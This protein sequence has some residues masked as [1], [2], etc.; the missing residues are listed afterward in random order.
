MPHLGIDYSAPIGTPVSSV[1]SGRVVFA[2]WQRGFGNYAEVK[3]NSK[4]LS[5]Y[6][7]LSRFAKGIKTGAYVKQG[8]IIGYVG[9]TG[10]TTG[11]HLDFRIKDRGQCVNFLKLR[12][13]VASGGL[14]SKK[15][16]A[17]FQKATR[18][19]VQELNQ[20]IKAGS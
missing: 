20:L 4:Y 11:P 13:R 18:G 3:H 19:L 10:N 17:E 6:G 2:G 7:H 5:G 9:M 1:A 16:R 14:I 15:K 12:N 8:K